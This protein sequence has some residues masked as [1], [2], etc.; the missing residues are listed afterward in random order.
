MAT[1][2]PGVQWLFRVCPYSRLLVVLLCILP[3]SALSQSGSYPRLL[4]DAHDIQ[5]AKEW[6]TKYSWYRN[7]IEV[8]KREVDAF[9]Q[10]RPI[11]VSPIKQTYE[12]KMYACPKHDAG[13]LYEENRPSGHRCSV[14]TTEIVR[15]AKY[16]AAWA[17]WYNR[18]LATRLVWM[19]ILYQL[20]DDDRYAD[21]GREIL[22]TFADLY[23]KYPTS[24][25]ILG[26]AHV[27]FGTLSESFWGVDMAYG[28]DLLYNYKGFSESDR[29]KLK[30]KFF[31][32]L[33]HI[34]QQFPESASNRQLWYNNVSAAVG[35]LYNDQE[36]IDFALKGK[37]GFTWQ[38]GSATPE[39][40]FWAEWSGYHFVALRGMIHL[41]EMARHNGIDL[42]HVEIAGRSMKKMFDAPFELILPNYE[43]PRS[44]DSGGGNIL[45]YA[46]YYEVGYALYRD[47]KYLALL[48]KTSMMRG[49][50]IVGETSALGQDKAPVTIF[51]LSPEL[52]GSSEDFIPE[53]SVNMEGNGFAVLRNG[54]GNDRRYL[55][56]DYGIMG[57]E[58]GH[59]DR[60][61][62]GYFANGRNWIV[63]PLNESYF[64]PNLQL[65]YRQSIAHMTPVLDQ[66][67]QTWTNGYGRFF[68][69]LPSLQ[70]V[71]GASTTAYPGS[72]ITRTLV[73][74]GDYFL[75]LV[76]LESPDKRMIDWPLQSFGGLS[77]E[78][79]DLRSEPRDLFGHEPGIAGYDQL[80]NV[81]ADHQAM[82]WSGVFT[83][84]GGHLMVR[85]VGEPGTTVFQV[86]APSIGG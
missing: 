83:D 18:V 24:N 56:L 77:L 63:D 31:Y 70:V 65:W 55:Y 22:M 76:D 32:P 15:G 69:A 28:Y 38:L 68:G 82:N 33:A 17:G 52:P 2:M 75:D 85:A 46:V 78:G 27:F 40:G 13:L 11:F 50:Q 47:P 29:R 10:H 9:I 39:S 43:F 67:T 30:E 25:T 6:M 73:Q 34:T 35:F 48:N 36:L 26:P 80:R 53:Q 74:V 3:F 23:L 12:Y 37:Y 1:M 59:P 79:L 71:S 57:G 86:S 72:E 16:D 84:K 21:A 81:R 60:L 58:H 14:D 42:Y 7:M 8:H 20:Y 62:I 5:Q 51:N 49:T 66:T 44:K 45:E 41:A 19:G 54:R 61:Q 4:A 64:N